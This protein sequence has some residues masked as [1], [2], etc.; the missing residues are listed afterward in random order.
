MSLRTD[1]VIVAE[2]SE[3]VLPLATASL[4]EEFRYQS[5]PLCVIDAVFSISISYT[6]VQRVVF[7]YCK[8]TNQGR[9][10]LGEALPSVVEQESI[11]AFCGRP[12]Q[13]D[14]A[15]MAI[16][17][18]GSR[19]RTS[20]RNGIL[21]SDAVAR[22][23]GCLSSHGVDYLQ[24]VSR[25]ADSTKFE[26]DIRRIPGQLSGLSLKYFWM[27]AGS[28][29]FVKPDRMVLRFLASALSREVS[30]GDAMPLLQA[31]CERLAGRHPSLTP[32]LLDH[33]VWKYQRGREKP[34]AKCS[35]TGRAAGSLEI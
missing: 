8:Y 25:V 21:K 3:R 1:G 35:P 22:F 28:E 7:R 33:E 11:T 23:A 4:G 30:T 16:E 2:Y 18:Y 29:Q 27:L 9:V 26:N 19:N 10:R 32:R 6:I 17:V 24:D 14:P 5:L 34:G 31:A 20:P 13:V 15:S 12:E